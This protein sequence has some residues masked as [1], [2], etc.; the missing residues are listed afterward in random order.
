M[1]SNLPHH[2]AIFSA[3]FFPHVGGIESYTASLARELVS[4]GNA[5]TVV[6]SRLDGSPEI[7]LRED[8]I[9]VMRLPTHVFM[10]GRFPV[11]NKTKHYEELLNALSSMSVDRVLVNTRFYR[12]SLEGLRFAQR[13]D[14]PVIVLD[15]G[16]AHLTLGNVAADI[17]IEKYEHA[18]TRKVKGFNPVFAGVSEKS[19]AWLEHFGI[20][21]NVIIPN[22]I[23]AQEF[24]AEASSK[25]YRDVL[26]LQRSDLLVAF[27]GRITPEKGP[28][29][30]LE[31]IK[32][33]DCPN[34]HVVFA[35]EGFLR[36]KLES[37]KQVNAHFLGK[38]DRGDLSSLLQQAD[39]FCLPSRSEGFCTSLLEASSWG[40][41]SVVT[42][43]G[44]AREIIRDHT[45]GMIIDSVEPHVIAK[46][47]DELIQMGS[48][49]RAGMGKKACSVVEES[50]S[51][52]NTVKALETAFSS[53]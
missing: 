26:G 20:N 9:T 23:N 43:F 2:Y 31:A 44:G 4:C 50:F 25:D 3:Q 41:P 16:S 22:G 1:G 38:I 17:L 28:D 35:G 13:V 37:D 39:I 40:T 27:V 34:V 6:T 47:L 48:I 10:N 18:V 46:A 14:A 33:L 19:I 11:S 29:K 8:G 21:T 51:W 53:R 7:E 52:R 49:E 15:H 30:L 36:G 24:R 12:H 42:D 32:L 45:Y 5:A